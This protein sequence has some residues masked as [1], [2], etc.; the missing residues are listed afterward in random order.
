VQLESVDFTPKTKEFRQNETKERFGMR[1]EKYADDKYYPRIIKKTSVP[2]PYENIDFLIDFGMPSISELEFNGKLDEYLDAIYDKKTKDVN[3]DWFEIV[4]NKIRNYRQMLL[5]ILNVKVTV[6]SNNNG[7]NLLKEWR[8]D[9]KV[10]PPVTQEVDAIKHLFSKPDAQKTILE[11]NIEKINGFLYKKTDEREKTIFQE[12]LF[13][14]AMG[15]IG[16][17]Y[18]DFVKRGE[19]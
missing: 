7:A 13:N 19:K 2:E 17:L 6:L 16:G 11:K 4:A 14:I 18:K 1:Y 15:N 9:E 10:P 8:P 12:I 5:F 3:R